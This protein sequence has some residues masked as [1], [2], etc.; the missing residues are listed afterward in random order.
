[1]NSMVPKKPSVLFYN[2]GAKFG[3]AENV[4]LKFLSHGSDQADYS[5]LLNEP[6]PFQDRLEASE[7]PVSII[8]TKAHRFYDIKR[9]DGLGFR[10]LLLLPSFLN[11]FRKTVLFF[12]N[13]EFDLIVSN[14]YKSHIILGCA[15]WVMKTPTAWRFHDILQ[16]EYEYNN[17]SR[18]NLSVLKFLARGVEEISVVSQAV[19]DSFI[20]NGFEASKVKVVH[21]GLEQSNSKRDNDSLNDKLRLGWIGQFTPW[22]GIE[23]FLGLAVQI[24]DLGKS[25]GKLVE[26]QIAGSALFDDQSYE[27]QLKAMVPETHQDRILFLGHLSNVDEFYSAIDIFFHTATAPDPFPTT[28]LEAGAHGLLVLA[29]PLGGAREVIEDGINGYIRSIKN[30]DDVL[31][32]MVEIFNDPHKHLALGA[33]LRTKIQTTFTPEIYHTE[34]EAELLWLSRP[35]PR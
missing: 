16:N 29:S 22:K 30:Q 34:L 11:L 33:E 24:I 9:G 13:N 2:F 17:F 14:T 8:E 26:I 23:E 5:V 12:R 18:L 31:K 3:G 32:L 7:I 28:V 21:N 15:A 10:F 35:K 20:N 6:G 27:E 25:Y 1:M 19:A 4:L